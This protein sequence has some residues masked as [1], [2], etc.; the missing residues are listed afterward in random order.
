MLTASA[1]RFSPFGPLA[2]AAPGCDLN[3]AVHVDDS[4]E[5]RAM[6]YQAILGELLGLMLGSWMRRAAGHQVFF[7]VI[8][9]KSHVAIMPCWTFVCVAPFPL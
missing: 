9:S 8:D 2:I 7:V 4:I 3:I 1:G 6:P 5:I